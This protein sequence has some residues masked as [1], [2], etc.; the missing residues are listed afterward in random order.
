MMLFDLLH[1]ISVDD[2]LIDCAQYAFYS[3]QLSFVPFFIHFIVVVI[4]IIIIIIII[5]TT[6]I[7][8]QSPI[9]FKDF[10]SLNAKVTISQYF[11]VE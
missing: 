7:Q 11:C 9:D 3:S 6:I 8:F 5:T 4:I 1:D 10:N 2:D